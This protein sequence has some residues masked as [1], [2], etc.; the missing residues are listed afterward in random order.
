MS[1]QGNA[2]IS[3]LLLLIIAAGI[4]AFWYFGRTRPI[5]VRHETHRNRRSS[6]CTTCRGAGTCNCEA[7]GG[8]GSVEA[9][10]VCSKC[11]GTGKHRWRF[12]DSPDAPCQRCRGAGTIPTRVMCATCRGTGKTACKKCGGTGRV[13]S[14]SRSSSTTV[15]IG[16]S[17]WE[18]ALRL[19]ALPTDPNPCPQRNASGGYA[20]V[21]KY[22]ELHSK[23]RR[24]DVQE[25]GTFKTNGPAWT[26]IASLQLRTSDGKVA[27]RMM[28]FVVQNRKLTEGRLLE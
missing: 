17:A 18:R 4:C 23:K 8:F 22:I 3:Q 24:I 27:S 15:V 5:L 16:F 12:N 14:T 2:R 28:E 7:C 1:T 13:A 21:T 6:I 11:K 20:I 10:K 9:A 25:W 19:F 26:M